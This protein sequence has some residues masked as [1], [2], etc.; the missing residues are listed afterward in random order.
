MLENLIIIGNMVIVGVSGECNKF[1]AF[2][3]LKILLNNIPDPDAMFFSLY[4][5]KLEGNDTDQGWAESIFKR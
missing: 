3:K 2:C 1:M 5:A 4:M